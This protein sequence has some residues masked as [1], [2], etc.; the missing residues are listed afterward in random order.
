MNAQQ[1]KLRSGVYY[2]GMLL[3]FDYKTKII[4][5]YFETYKGYNPLTGKPESF[6]RF[7]IKGEIAGDSMRVGVFYP[8]WTDTILGR[9]YIEGDSTLNLK[10]QS[11]PDTW[12]SVEDD[13]IVYKGMQLDLDHSV[14]WI[15]IGMIS[16]DHV[17]IYNDYGNVNAK[18]VSFAKYKECV[19]VLVRKKGWLK[20]EIIKD[21]EV[22]TSGW[23]E[24][25]YFN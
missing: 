6:C 20:I 14:N 7:F 16:R 2:I 24:D 25:I 17:K 12:S 18:P 5:G 19:K 4:S 23:I 10:L 11:E 9:I 1:K 15:E 3:A 13:N 21:E 8:E 22:M